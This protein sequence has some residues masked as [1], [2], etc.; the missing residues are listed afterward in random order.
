MF[1]C[2]LLV[3]CDKK[4][5]PEREVIRSSYGY[6]CEVLA[7]GERSAAVRCWESKGPPPKKK[8]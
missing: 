3:G 4:E 2:F 1:L 8:E 6:D 5:E 7:R